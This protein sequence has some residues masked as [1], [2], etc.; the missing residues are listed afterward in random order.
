MSLPRVPKL[1]MGQT[2]GGSSSLLTMRAARRDVAKNQKEPLLSIYSRVTLPQ[3]F[4]DY[5]DGLGVP[6][7]VLQGEWRGWRRRA[8]W[9]NQALELN[10]VTQEAAQAEGITIITRSSLTNGLGLSTVDRLPNGLLLEPNHEDAGDRNRLGDTNRID[11][12]NNVGS[13]EGMPYGEP[14][15]LVIAEVQ[16]RTIAYLF[17]FEEIQSPEHVNCDVLFG[18]AIRLSQNRE[19]QEAY[20]AGRVERLGDAI[21]EVGLSLPD[22][23]LTTLRQ[24]TDQHF[25][26][27]RSYEQ[28]IAT[29]RTTA[30]NLQ[31]EIDAVLAMQ[32]NG[33]EDRGDAI[34]TQWR[35]LMEHP[36]VR[37]ST[38]TFNAATRQVAYETVHLHMSEPFGERLSLGEFK[39]T[40]TLGEAAHGVRLNNQTGVRESW[41]HP[42]VSGG[43]ACWGNMESEISNSLMNGD[44]ALANE[45]ILRYLQHWN[46][47]DEYGRHSQ[48]WRSDPVPVPAS[49]ETVAA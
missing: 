32:E 37:T 1:L 31:L 46:P 18:N 8:E 44:L 22:N 9:S 42:H 26:N 35:L 25:N 20:Q 41:D 33:G 48:F 14:G 3:A 6:V 30:R 11:V 38:L 24:Q 23:R 15:G 19:E 27:I 34:R 43:G 21:A 13:L 29:E 10:G 5:L 2:V 40:F 49:G 28:Q 17:A 16:E 4:T 45:S 47:D 7:R 36:L 12:G 39:I